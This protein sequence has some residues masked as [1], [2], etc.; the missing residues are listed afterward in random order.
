[1]LGN[2]LSDAAQFNM[3]TRPLI[4][5]RFDLEQTP[6]LLTGGDGVG[7]D[8]RNGSSSPDYVDGELYVLDCESSSPLP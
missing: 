6:C 2:V 1:M 3:I 8:G 5:L 7:Y 4:Q